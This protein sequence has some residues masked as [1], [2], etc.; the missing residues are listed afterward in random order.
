MLDY[1]QVQKR[2]RADSLVQIL[3]VLLLNGID[4]DL[5]EMIDI[6][7]EVKEDTDYV[8]SKAC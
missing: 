7:A 8:T 5:I 4:E 6:V 3:L 1:V 2:D